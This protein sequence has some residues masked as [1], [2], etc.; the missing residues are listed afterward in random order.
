[1]TKQQ[2]IIFSGPD[3]CG[4]TQ[5]A[6]ELSRRLGI[7]YYKSSSE[8]EAFLGKK[9]LFINQL[10]YSLPQM[11]DLVKQTGVSVVFDRGFPC[12]WAYARALGRETDLTMLD[13]VDQRF[14]ELG[15]RVVVCR[16]SSYVGITDDLD[17]RINQQM[18]EIIDGHYRDFEKYFTR[19]KTYSLNVDDEDLDR[20]VAEVL[21]WMA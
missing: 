3:M 11:I 5:I 8:H 10:R 18:L 4:K 1:M 17:P 21:G 7:S 9:D 20:E 6:K 13:Y 16:R 19:C 15:A 2:V 14:N 12:E